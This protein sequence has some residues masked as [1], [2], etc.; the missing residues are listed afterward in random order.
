[1]LKSLRARLVL[2]FLG[3]T[4][5]LFC[6]AGAA[7]HMQLSRGLYQ[8]FDNDLLKQ[9]QSLAKLSE[10]YQGGMSFKWE[11]FDPQMTM[12]EDPQDGKGYIFLLRSGD[13]RSNYSTDAFGGVYPAV[14][15]PRGRVIHRDIDLPDG[16]HARYVS[17][18]FLPPIDDELD[19]PNPQTATIA[20]ARRTIDIQSQMSRILWTLLVAGG[21]AMLLAL[22]ITL[23]FVGHSLR[24]LGPVL[25]QLN[26]LGEGDLSRRVQGQTLP[27]ELKPLIG[28][29]NQL[30]AGLESRI[31]RERRFIADAAHEFRTPIAGARANLELLTLQRVAG[32]LSG[33]DE[34]RTCLGSIDQ[35]KLVCD[36]L[37]LLAGLEDGRH[38][39]EWQEVDLLEFVE[40]TAHAFEKIGERAGVTIKWT[41][42]HTAMVK[43]DPV[44]LNM[45]VSNL[46][47]NASSYSSPN[48]PIEVATCVD[49][50]EFSLTIRNTV[51]NGVEIDGEQAVEPFWRADEARVFGRRHT[52]LG[53]AICKSAAEKIG[54]EFSCGMDDHHHFVVQLRQAI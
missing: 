8:Q 17:F 30:L 19:C 15:L 42:R 46:L 45:I 31:R 22:L 39:I 12:S 13:G 24:T 16:T 49:D 48:T 3:A 4:L 41:S 32:G 44:L 23:W 26:G 52:G 38:S 2:G 25:S 34:I 20:V 36:R 33:S 29:I 6:G 18:E 5:I 37:M 1:M 21:G 51:P 28:S 11:D 54:G 7:V 53:L 27:T 47:D 43:T 50:G 35:L 40:S 14:E 9:A 10:Q